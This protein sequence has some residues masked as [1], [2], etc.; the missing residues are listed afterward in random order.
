MLGAGLS[1]PPLLMHLATYR[2]PTRRFAS[3]LR[4]V[5][6]TFFSSVAILFA[7][8]TGFLANDVWERHRQAARSVSAERDSILALTTLGVA[9]V[10]DMAPLQAALHTYVTAVVNDE[11]PRMTD[12]QHSVAAE[13]A[14]GDVLR[15]VADP[16]LS[17][18]AGSVAHAAMLRLALD[19][20][21]ARNDRLA[22]SG[23]EYDQVK[24]ATVL[25]LVLFTQFAIAVVHLEHPRS[26]IVALGTF[27]SAVV[28]TLGL[29]AV[30]ERPFDGAN[31][32]SPRPLHDLLSIVSPPA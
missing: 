29:L 27:T 20:R 31:P 28:L 32:I 23:A 2:L 19:I 16:T 21:A 17:M 22:I 18:T 10:A 3:S 5:V 25:A 7:L 26:Q 6:P 14:L 1:A 13:A 4:G 9:T 8:L 24:W 30:R 15:A 11:W 12:Q